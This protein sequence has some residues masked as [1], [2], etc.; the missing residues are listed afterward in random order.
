MTTW[1]F[2]DQTEFTRI[3]V[4]IRAVL[5]EERS[6]FQTV[7]ILDSI[8]YGRML[9]LDDVIQVT[10]FDEFVYH[11]MLA[12]VPLHA[13]ENPQAVLVVGG[14][15]GGMVREA[16]KHPSVTRVV[17]A[18]IDEAVIRACTLHMPAVSSALVAN[19]KLEIQ[20]GD[21]VEYIKQAHQEFDLIIVDSSDPVG[22]GEGLFTKEF[23]SNVFQALKPGGMVTVQGESPWLHRPLV[24]RIVTD[25]ASIF[26]VAKLYLGNVPTYPSGIMAF[27]VGSKG[28]DPAVPL[29]EALPGLRYYSATIHQNAFDLPWHL[30]L[31]QMEEGPFTFF[32]SWETLN[33]LKE[34]E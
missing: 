16:C 3:G 26:P 24:R 12:H 21:A 8:E 2:E 17:L 1:F 23:Y 14:G 31:E 34:R 11:E 10:E 28:R 18:E 9:V 15:D 25:I 30:Q 29:R 33:R 32:S 5:H 13:L 4:R 7:K 22:I 27:P 6:P 19:P 20:I